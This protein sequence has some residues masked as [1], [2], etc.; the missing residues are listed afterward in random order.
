MSLVYPFGSLVSQVRVEIM[1]SL[2][3]NTVHRETRVALLHGDKLEQLHIIKPGRSSLVG[4]LFK[5]QVRRIVPSL[6]A[7][8]VDF[9]ADKNGF[10]SLTDICLPPLKK[11][12]TKQPLQPT[13]NQFLHEGQQ[14][15][16]QVIKDPIDDKGA[17]LT[18]KISLA[19]R[20]L[21]F[22]P[23]GRRLK[24]SHLL[25]D[26]EERNR[27]KAVSRELIDEKQGKDCLAR[28][29][30]ILRSQARFADRQSL[31]ADLD[32]LFSLWS[33]LQ[34]TFTTTKAPAIVH[35]ELPLEKQLI[36]QFSPEGLDKIVVDDREKYSDL[37]EFCRSESVVEDLH[38]HSDLSSLPLFQ[39][40]GIETQI[41]DALARKIDL[42]K[43]GHVVFDQTEAMVVID[44][45]TGAS[46]GQGSI[47]KTHY[48]TNL[49]AAGVIARQIRLRNLSG[50]IVIDFIDMQPAAD[51]SRLLAELKTAMIDEG[52]DIYISNF[53]E[54]GLV[55]IRRKRRAASLS[56]ILREQ[57]DACSGSG[58]VKS[59]DSVFIDIWRTVS[60]VSK[61]NHGKNLEL[62]ASLEV[63]DYLQYSRDFLLHELKEKFNCMIELK[64]QPRYFREQ[65]SV[66]PIYAEK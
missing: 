20:F 42:P 59:L 24:V 51:R 64:H 36:K 49:E 52:S 10:L 47:D 56:N 41:A 3:I 63:T 58:H 4:N 11:S 50:I 54:L 48:E 2:L 32:Y 17:R 27:L 28:S 7:A 40:H 38:F 21:V 39:H 61:T 33:S 14:I 35:R 19:S 44:V 18:T 55:Q 62:Q 31:S 25:K 30:Y 66:V 8:F 29:G 34:K 13:I 53:T 46:A 60:H 15:L 16:V 22:L 5:G 1:H 12:A 43:G 23:F 57:C 26:V 9:G 6:E 45:N 37:L 65:F